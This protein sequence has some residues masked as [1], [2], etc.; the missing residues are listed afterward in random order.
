MFICV[1]SRSILGPYSAS[2]TSVT[3]AVPS[4]LKWPALEVLQSLISS[5][6]ARNEWSCNSI[7]SISLTDCTRA[8]FIYVQFR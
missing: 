4:E 2:I 8:D 5:G 1:V 6:N 7:P 3:G